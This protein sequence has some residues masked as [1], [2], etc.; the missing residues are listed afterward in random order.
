MNEAVV[1][2]L[3]VLVLEGLWK[4]SRN[5]KQ[6]SRR[7]DRDSNLGPAKYRSEALEHELAQSFI[8]CNEGTERCIQAPGD[9]DIS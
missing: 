3:T 8:Q 9:R 5:I 4:T 6:N 1:A 7:P 2:Y